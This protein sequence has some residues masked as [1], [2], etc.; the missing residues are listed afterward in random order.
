[1]R[2]RL[3]SPTLRDGAYTLRHTPTLTLLELRPK[4]Q[5]LFKK[6]TQIIPAE[7]RITMSKY[8]QIK[9]NVTE[10]VHAKLVQIAK[11]HNITLAELFR[12]SVH[13]SIKNAPSRRRETS[14]IIYKQTDP[15]L[16]Y[17]VNKIGVNINQI[18]KHLNSGEDKLKLQTLYLIYEEVMSL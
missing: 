3:V 10:D 6:V 11:K 5:L 15:Y 4:T 2:A 18:A 12:V 1:V 17:E 14:K 8:K 7:R 13:T 16:L 9:V